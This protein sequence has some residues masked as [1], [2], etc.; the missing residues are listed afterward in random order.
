MGGLPKLLR[1]HPAARDFNR[2][3]AKLQIQAAI[4][5]NFIARGIPKLW[6]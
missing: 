2:Q 3:V 4:R 6:P 5:N 1:Q